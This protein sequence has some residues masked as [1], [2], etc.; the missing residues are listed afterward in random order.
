MRAL[1]TRLALFA[2]CLI[3]LLVNVACAG[4]GRLAPG[5][6]GWA[7]GHAGS[8]PEAGAPEPWRAGKP[9]PKKEGLRQLDEYLARL[10]LKRGVLVIF[11]R[12]REAEGILK[13]ARFEEATTPGGRRVTLLRG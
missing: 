2:A 7:G 10:G 4:T 6:A 3:P 9:D 1:A 5:P 13:K 8:P 11:D 12:R